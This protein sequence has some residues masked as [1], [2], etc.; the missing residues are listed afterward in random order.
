[1]LTSSDLF[2]EDTNLAFIRRPKGVQ[3]SIFDDDD[4]DDDDG[5]EGD[6]EEAK[7]NRKGK[8]KDIQ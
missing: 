3:K 8:S 7:L 6:D 2:S 5:V 4:D 1:M